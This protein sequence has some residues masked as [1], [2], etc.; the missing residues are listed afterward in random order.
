MLLFPSIPF[1]SILVFSKIKNCYFLPFSLLFPSTLKSLKNKEWKEIV[2]ST[3]L[4]PSTLL[5]LE[6][7]LKKWNGMEG[8]SNAVLKPKWLMKNKTWQS[9]EKNC[10]WKCKFSSTTLFLESSQ[11]NFSSPKKIRQMKA[12][13]WLA[14]SS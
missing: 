9:D 3:L 13:H 5:F 11:Q 4:F 1:H 10:L 2:I 14:Q 6:K 8:N 12:G 7:T